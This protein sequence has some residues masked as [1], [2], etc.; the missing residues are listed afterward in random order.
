MIS[1][2]ALDPD[3]GGAG[4]P[5]QC[6]LVW[7]EAPGHVVSS[8]RGEGAPDSVLWFGRWSWME[9]GRVLPL[10]NLT[11]SV[12]TGVSEGPDADCSSFGA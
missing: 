9:S 11:G 5:D 3:S 10:R 7:L 6:P 1:A 4:G 2:V 12:R 8:E